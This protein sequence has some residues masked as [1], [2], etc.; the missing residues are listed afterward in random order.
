MCFHAAAADTVDTVLQGSE[1]AIA[2][3]GGHFT[4][5][6]DR[7]VMTYS[8]T[9]LKDDVPK[10]MGVLADAVKV[11]AC[12]GPSQIFAPFAS[13]VHLLR[14]CFCIFCASSCFRS[15][16]SALVGIIVERALLLVAVIYTLVATIAAACQRSRKAWFCGCDSQSRDLSQARPDAGTTLFF[17]C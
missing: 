9:V 10:A 2:A 16:P 17:F 3:M 15:A 5:S 13:C 4:Q 11:R 1:P 6:V 8:A 14:V 12:L 7:E